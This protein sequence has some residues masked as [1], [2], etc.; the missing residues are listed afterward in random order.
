MECA[1][2]GDATKY[3]IATYDLRTFSDLLPIVS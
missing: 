2:I 1:A 3:G